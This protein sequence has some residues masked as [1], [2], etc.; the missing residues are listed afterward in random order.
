[1]KEEVT[2]IA[3]GYTNLA[4]T[5]NLKAPKDKIDKPEWSIFP[6]TEAEEVRK[7]FQYGVKK[8]GKPFTYRFGTGVP[9]KDL[10]DA[11]F[12]HL[13]AIQSGEIY[14]KESELL[15]WAHVAAN[16]LMSIFTVTKRS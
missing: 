7:V 10:L 8:Y 13:I 2:E 5:E 12:R 15:H 9:E 4:H 14:D 11:A 3:N 1:M 16:A 6:F